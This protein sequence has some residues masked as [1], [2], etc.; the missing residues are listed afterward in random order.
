MELLI[1]G[2]QYPMKLVIRF[3]LEMFP[4][5][6]SLFRITNVC[7]KKLFYV[8]FFFT[9]IVKRFGLCPNKE[10]ICG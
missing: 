8:F 4:L 7:I 2:I 9:D 1:L 10:E 6:P 3:I 5:C